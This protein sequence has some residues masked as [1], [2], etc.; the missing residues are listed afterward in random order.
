MYKVIKLGKK[1]HV[2]LMEVYNL[3]EH[4]NGIAAVL[5]SWLLLREETD[6]LCLSRQK[7]L[8]NLVYCTLSLKK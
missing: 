7:V 3:M 8:K 5:F 4:Y 2:N 6:E 1:I